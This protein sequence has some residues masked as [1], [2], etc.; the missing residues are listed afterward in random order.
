MLRRQD[1]DDRPRSA[2]SRADLVQFIADS[3]AARDLLVFASSPACE[4]IRSWMAGER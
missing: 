1:F 4:A 2:L 3:D